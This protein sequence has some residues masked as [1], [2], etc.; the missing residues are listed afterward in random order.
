MYWSDLKVTTSPNSNLGVGAGVPA[1]K[2]ATTINV[3]NTDA[4]KTL[5]HIGIGVPCPGITIISPIG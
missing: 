1:S 5:Y 4:K 3:T 2:K